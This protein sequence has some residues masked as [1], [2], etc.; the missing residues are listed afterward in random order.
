MVLAKKW[1]TAYKY[2]CAEK[3]LADDLFIPPTGVN[4]TDMTNTI[5]EA[6][7]AVKSLQDNSPASQNINQEDI[8]AEIEKIN[9]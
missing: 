4:F 5:T 7:A 6:Q 9:N 1:E 2:D 3:G 8:E